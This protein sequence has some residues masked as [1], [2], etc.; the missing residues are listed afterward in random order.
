MKRLLLVSLVG[1]SLLFVTR[2]SAQEEPRTP[3]P[4]TDFERWW[5]TPVEFVLFFF[6][7]TNAGVE[8]QKTGVVTWIVLLALLLGKPLGISVATWLAERAG[9][10]RPEGLAWR[11]L[12][13]LGIAAGI[14][15]TV[16]LFFATAAF[17]AGATQDEAKLGAMLSVGAAVLALAA[18]QMLG[19][20]GARRRE[21]S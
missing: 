8:V 10:R 19:A 9:L 14:G 1:G 18:A 5:S 6:A 17:S 15:F 2:G 20:G 16:S 13:V 3:D 7:L 12:L 4:L 11:E 21:F